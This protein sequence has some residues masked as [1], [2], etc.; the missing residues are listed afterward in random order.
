[1]EIVWLGYS[2]FRIRGRPAAKEVA[3]VTDPCPPT[4]GYTIGKQNAMAVTISHDHANHSYRKGV[5]GEPQVLDSPGEYEIQGAFFTSIRTYR[6]REKGTVRGRNL[7]FVI[8]ME[9]ISICHLGALG[10]IPTAEQVEKL[11]GVD[12]LLIPVGGTTTIDGAHAAEVVSML[13]PRLVVPMHYGTPVAPTLEPLDRFLKEMGVKSPEPQ[14]KLP[15][16]R[17]TL[18]NET[19]LIVLNPKQR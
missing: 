5:S 15:I 9:D 11:T 10:H 3:V 14:V 8:E 6:D 4:S 16:S 12:V 13:E 19:Q 17:K 18:P 1:M 7:V 2:C